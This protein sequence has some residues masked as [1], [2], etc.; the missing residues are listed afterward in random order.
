MFQLIHTAHS[1]HFVHQWTITVDDLLWAWISIREAC[2][3][4]S[5]ESVLLLPQIVICWHFWSY[6]R[7]CEEHIQD[8]LLNMKVEVEDGGSEETMEHLRQI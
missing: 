7:T 4:G 5:T 8:F 2:T 3:L 1:H 6:V